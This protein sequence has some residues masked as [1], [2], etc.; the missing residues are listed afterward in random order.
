MGHNDSRVVRDCDSYLFLDHRSHC[1]VIEILPD[2]LQVSDK[3]AFG[4]SSQEPAPTQGSQGTARGGW[5]TA[6]YL[7]SWRDDI[8][9]AVCRALPQGYE[10]TLFVSSLYI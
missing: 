3:R 9:I 6:E 4:D 7:L 10:K 5:R 8:L 2:L 1:V